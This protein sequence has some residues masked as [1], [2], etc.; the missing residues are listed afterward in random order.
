MMAWYNPKTKKAEIL[1]NYEEEEKTPSVVYFGKNEILVGTPAKN[2]LD[3]VNE[4]EQYRV[5]SNVKRGLNISTVVLDGKKI[6]PVE[7]ASA[8]MHKLKSDAERLHFKQ[9]LTRAVITYPASFG[10]SQRDKLRDAAQMAKFS[11]VK[12]L[13]EPVAA[14]KA[15]GY[16][17]YKV[18]NYL[19]VFDMGGG[20]FDVAVL[21]R[22]HDGSSSVVLPPKGLSDCGGYDLD[23]E[24][25]AYFNERA[26]ERLKRGINLT[27]DINPQIL[28]RCRRFK[29]ILSSR[30][31]VTLS[32]PLP[33]QNGTE[34]FDER[35]SRTVFES[36]ITKYINRTVQLTKEMMQDAHARNYAV[37]SVLL[38]GGSS[39]VPLALRMLKQ[40]QLVVE[41]WQQREK[42]VVLGAAY[43]GHEQWGT[44][45]TVY[46]IDVAIPLTLP[47][48]PT[49]TP[50]E[51]Y[52]NAVIEAYSSQKLKPADLNHL[53]SIAESLD[54]SREEAAIIERRVMRGTKEEIFQYQRQQDRGQYRMAVVRVWNVNRKHWT[55]AHVDA[56]YQLQN[57]LGL[58]KEEA[59]LIEKE[60]IGS[61]K[62]SIPLDIGEPGLR[63]YNPPAPA[64]GPYPPVDLRLI[65]PGQSS[66]LQKPD[67]PPGSNITSPPGT[68]R[69]VL[70]EPEVAVPVTKEGRVLTIIG[71]FFLI[72]LLLFCLLMAIGAFS[73][74]A[75]SGGIVILIISA[76]LFWLLVRKKDSVD[77]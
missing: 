21:Q 38:I 8:I 45:T 7:V 50:A 20:T 72:A 1:L 43:F 37:E 22:A 54:L 18:S 11:E 27:N 74:G 60:V 64:T 56:L 63:P 36:R 67:T 35:L 4:Q 17:G 55:N 48:P 59:V 9:P 24:L 34:M 25:Y 61:T 16:E 40:E 47:P 69:Q 49:R 19:L 32:V 70:S 44:P 6:K 28:E 66:T 12:L 29:E 62:E 15:Y 57:S 75:S 65:H 2:M 30:E 53:S 41:E 5:I 77:E 68:G 39:K 31:E 46:P 3:D 58:S 76:V 13:P 73:S 51:M 33:S 14:A 26:L 42:A 10:P 71:K 23:L 52:Q